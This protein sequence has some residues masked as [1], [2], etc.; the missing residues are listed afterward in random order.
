MRTF[1]SGRSRRR[2]RRRTASRRNASAAG[3]SFSDTLPSRPWDGAETRNSGNE[4]KIAGRSVILSSSTTAGSLRRTP[5]E[6][7]AATPFET[8][9]RPFLATL[10]SGLTSGSGGEATSHSDTAR[11]SAWRS[12][13]VASGTG[14]SPVPERSASDLCR[15][16]NIRLILTRFERHRHIQISAAGYWLTQRRIQIAK[17]FRGTLYIHFV[18]GSAAV[19]ITE[20]VR[21]EA[22]LSC[23][24]FDDINGDG[25]LLSRI[26]DDQSVFADGVDQPGKSAR[27]PIDGLDHIGR[28][29]TAWLPFRSG[30]AQPMLDIFCCLLR[31]QRTQLGAKRDSLLELTQPNRIQLLIQFRLTDKDDLYQFIVSGLEIG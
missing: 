22:E 11:R 3:V 5:F 6:T 17:Y 4:S 31:V 15:A 29:Q 1:F 23:Y 2:C 8:G 18:L 14:E 28:E 21:I 20:E 12:N 26:R 16:S 7:G 13:S 25:R 30:Y 9:A 19:G 27:V 24:I 10:R